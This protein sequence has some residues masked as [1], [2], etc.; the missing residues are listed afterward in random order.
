MK[1]LLLAM[2][3][4]S[5]M[6][7]VAQD[8][9]VRIGM[10]LDGPSIFMDTFIPEMKQEIQTLLQRDY[11]VTF[12]EEHQLDSAYEVANIKSNLDFLMENDDVDLVLCMG[13]L[14]TL[15]AARRDTFSKPVF[16]PF[17]IDSTL[18]VYPH[19]GPASGI[20]NF[21]YLVTPSNVPRD[22]DLISRMKPMKKVHVFVTDLF[23]DLIPDIRT[24]VEQAFKRHNIEVEYVLSKGK[25]DDIIAS[26]P[27]DMEMAYVTPLVRLNRDEKIKLY[28]T[29]AE[30]QVPSFSLRGREDVEI[31]LL[32]A[33][34]PKS[35]LMRWI[36][37]LALNIQRTLLGEDPGTFPTLLKESSQLVINMETAR[38]VNWYPSW[39][40][41]IT[42]DLI[43][44]E[45]E[46]VPR[47]YDLEKIINRAI[48]ANSSLQAAKA[49]MEATQ[50]QVD[51]LQANRK[52]Q[53]TGDVT[54]IAVDEDTSAASFGSQPETSSTAKVQLQQ[55]LFS[56]SLSSGIKA[57]KLA[58]DAARSSYERQR[59]DL[60]LDASERYLNFLKARTLYK[61][62]R[63]NLELTNSNLE[64]AQI[65]RDIGIGSPSELLRWQAQLAT[66][67]LEA[68]TA[69]NNADK[70]LYSLNQILQEPQEFMLRAEIPDMAESTNRMGIG[71]IQT[72]VNNTRDFERFRYFMV[73]EALRDAPELAQLDA[74]IQA[75]KIKVASD[76][77]AFYM[78]TVSLQANLSHSLHRD[79][80]TNPLGA[81]LPPGTTL[82]EQPDTG[83][84]AALNFSIPL[85][86]GGAKKAQL[87]IDRY[88]QEQLEQSREQAKLQIE[89][90]VRAGMQDIAT[91][92]V[93]IQLRQDAANAARENRELVSDAYSKGV[94]NLIDLLD[95]QNAALVAE[96]SASNALYDY[97]LALMRFQRAT[98]NFDYFLSRAEQEAF[99]DRLESFYKSHQ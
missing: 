62:R 88:G 92:S 58:A 39:D 25:L 7:G 67:K 80:V 70:A 72:Y 45:R 37:R 65:R 60:A 12:S 46:D 51:L 52:P 44:E 57:Q 89:L 41:Q 74:L 82:P 99:F 3:T 61:V 53:L 11:V 33:M 93:G 79:E 98:G 2:L 75:Q 56:D 85:Y 4:V 68:I 55:L 14:S 10:V 6:V 8:R 31:G 97:F 26:L 91:A 95:A 23:A 20:K 47:V 9:Q 17:G 1:Y 34:A 87:A 73:E 5:S 29:L 36:R 30:R 94:A 35:D 40:L 38:Q 66:D 43:H 83:W 90:R 28:K 78:P 32:A 15:E 22:A 76:K 18:P 63:E 96:L 59:L 71:R 49:E 21:N 81:I 13:V 27:K 69:K 77:R 19:K 64:T 54:A 84:N 50:L 42:A 48:E 24:Y 86:S 16:A